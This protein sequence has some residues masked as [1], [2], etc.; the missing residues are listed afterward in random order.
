MLAIT[1]IILHANPLISVDEATP[2]VSPFHWL[3][4]TLGDVRRGIALPW[5]CPPI[6]RFSAVDTLRNDMLHYYNI[7]VV[8]VVRR[9][10]IGVCVSVSMRFHYIHAHAPTPFV[11][12]HETQSV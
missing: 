6:L 3:H 1:I 9:M 11:P 10:R 4:D 7:A 12:G 2:G 8:A 5:T